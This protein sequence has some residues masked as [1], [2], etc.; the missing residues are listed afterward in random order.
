MYKNDLLGVTSFQGESGT[1][2]G[3][4]L[5]QYCSKARRGRPCYDC[6][7]LLDVGWF[8]QICGFCDEQ[9][10]DRIEHADM[11]IGQGFRQAK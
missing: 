10:V 5:V 7:P 1:F 6:Y 4:P 11:L 8:G 3:C 2:E 9:A